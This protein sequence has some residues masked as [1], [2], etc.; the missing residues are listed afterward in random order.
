M[1]WEDHLTS[2][3]LSFLICK[4]KD[5]S[6]IPKVL[7][8]VHVTLLLL[9][10][11]THMESHSLKGLLT[12]SSKLLPCCHHFTHIEPGSARQVKLLTQPMKSSD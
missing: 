6:S 12:T 11:F 5:I 1:G 8:D 7:P 2:L 10:H 9:N 4:A 3:I